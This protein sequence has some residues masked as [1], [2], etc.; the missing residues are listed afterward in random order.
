MKLLNILILFLI[1]VQISCQRGSECVMKIGSQTLTFEQVLPIIE[2]NSTLKRGNVNEQIIMDYLEGLYAPD[3]YYLEE[4]KVLGLADADSILEKTGEQGKRLLTRQQGPLYNKIVGDIKK[5][6]P[7]QL[8]ELY[9]K[10]LNQ[11]KLA[12]I[13]LPSKILADSIYKVLGKGANFSTLVKKY[14]FDRRWGDEQGEWHDWF[15]YGSLGGDFDDAVL[16]ARPLRPVGPIHTVYG[17]QIILVVKKKERPEKPFNK[18]VKWLENVYMGMERKRAFFNYQNSLPAKFNFQVNK[19]AAAIIQSLYTEIDGLPFVNSAGLSAEQ[20][21]TKL[22]TFKGG[23]L[24][25]EKFINFI[26]SKRPINVPPLNRID[27]IAEY[28]K[29]ASM[30][31]LMYLDALEN[32]V[33][34]D[35]GFQNSV[36]QFR[37]NLLRSE[38]KKRILMPFDVTEEDK[39]KR[40]EADSTFQIQEYE[41]VEK[42]IER[43]IRT[44]K[45]AQE[46]AR[47][48]AYMAAKFPLEF[49]KSGVR[50]IVSALGGN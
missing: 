10:R 48:I 47:Q 3:F 32:G 45:T 37:I 12:H 4:A 43:V 46:Q 33:D 21:S 35:E 19:E 39:V 17:Y 38:V 44:E 28:C 16:S 36:R 11:Y 7:D 15:L 2:K 27:A 9:D 50:R 23:F 20:R 18:V 25:I 34:N 22:A 6:T 42:W 31:D 49:C 1:L 26:G 14:S 30:T 24:S 13:L 29:I 5:P 40:Y 8:K 41:L